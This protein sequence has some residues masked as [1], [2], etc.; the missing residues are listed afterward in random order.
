M[1]QQQRFILALVASAAVLFIWTYLFPPPKAPQ[2]NANA[3]ANVQQA[4][5]PSASPT[6]Q[7]LATATPAP[8]QAS[9]SPAPTPDSLP[10]RKLRIVTPLYEATFDTHGAAATSWIL[11]KI[12]KSDGTMHDVSA[13]SSTKNN[14]Q[15]LELISTPPAGVAADQLFRPFQITTG[16]AAIDAALANRNYRT[17]GPNAESGDETINVPSGSKQIDFVI[18][19]EATGLDATKRLTFFADSYTTQLEVKL[20]RNNQP[21]PANILAIGPSVGDQG[22]QHHSFYAVPPEGMAVVDGKTQRFPADPI[23]RNP[24]GWFSSARPEGPDLQKVAGSAQSAGVGHTYFG[25]V[26]AEPHPGTGLELRTV[27][28]RPRQPAQHYLVTA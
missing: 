26:A 21:V 25:M 28:Y 19:D 2:P 1:K 17:F 9:S 8:A 12:K 3:N 7:A 23:H 15:P 16:D 5:S 4:A 13:A 11:K 14:P 20:T 18:H 6:A 27:A 22:I 10:Q 24:S